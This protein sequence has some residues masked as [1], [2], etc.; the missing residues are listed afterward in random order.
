MAGWVISQWHLIILHAFIPWLSWQHN[1]ALTVSIQS[2]ALLHCHWSNDL[3]FPHFL[4]EKGREPIS[5]ISICSDN[6]CKAPTEREVLPFGVEWDV[7]IQGPNK[8][9]CFSLSVF[10]H[11]KTYWL[12]CLPIHILMGKRTTRIWG[13]GGEENKRLSDDTSCRRDKNKIC[14]WWR[15]RNHRTWNHSCVHV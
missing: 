13:W 12:R 5:L 11:V 6:Y 9:P 7:A 2:I 1:Q 8:R 3:V 10:V 4:F 15:G 14:T